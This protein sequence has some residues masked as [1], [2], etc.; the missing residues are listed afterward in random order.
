MFQYKCT[1]TILPGGATKYSS[2][3]FLESR[4]SSSAQSPSIAVSSL[5]FNALIVH[6]QK[7]FSHRRPHKGYSCSSHL[8]VPHLSSST[9]SIGSTAD[10]ST[11][12]SWSACRMAFSKQ[13]RP[14]LVRKSSNASLSSLST[15]SAGIWADCKNQWCA[16]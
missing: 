15:R 6:R 4:S 2:T 8:S 5:R 7:V 16:A 9:E 12:R 14:C 13:T 10:V 11:T 3:M 1:R